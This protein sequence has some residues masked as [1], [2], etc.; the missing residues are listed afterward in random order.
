MIRHT[1]H[2]FEPGRRR[3][4]FR[5]SRGGGSR[6]TGFS[7]G[8]GRWK[9]STVWVCSTCEPIYRKRI[10]DG[11]IVILTIIGVIASGVLLA[12]LS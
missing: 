2:S 3:S 6:Q 8:E 11:F 1:W 5:I 10:R 4:Y 7:E 12:I 9:T